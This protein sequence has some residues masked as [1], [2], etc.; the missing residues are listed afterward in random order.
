MHIIKL[1]SRAILAA[2][3][4]ALPAAAFHPN[5]PQG[6]DPERAYQGL[7]QIDQIDLFSGRLTL[8]LPI[9]PF[10]LIYNSNVWRYVFD[11]ES[12]LEAWPD[13][14]STAGL[15]WHL[16]W[17]EVY[18]PDH[19]WYN[20]SEEWLYVSEDGGRHTF[21]QELH[22]GEDDGDLRVFYTRDGSYLRMTL[23]ADNCH[24]DI[25]FPDGTTRRF[26]GKLGHCGPDT[27]RIFSKMWNRFG[28]VHDPD[29]TVSYENDDTL[30]K[31]TDRYGRQHEVYLKKINDV[32]EGSPIAWMNRVVTEIRVQAPHNQTAI[33]KLHYVNSNQYLT[34]VSCKAGLANQ[35]A[36][37]RV[38]LL[39][40]VELPDGTSYDFADHFNPAAT[41]VPF[42]NR[43]CAAGIDD[44]PGTLQGVD[45]PTRGKLR[46]DYQRY[47]FPP[48]DNHSPFNT[49]AGVATRRM[50]FADDSEHGRWTYKTTSIARSDHDDAEMQTEVIYPTGDCTKHF[51]NARYWVTPSQGKGWEY[52]LPFT[53]LAP[54]EG[55][56]HL[57]TET[58]TSSTGTAC[59]GTK[60]RSTYL[61][62]RHDKLPGSV[63][64]DVNPAPGCATEADWLARNRQVDGTRV[65]YHDDVRNGVA[66][67]TDTELNGFDGLGHFRKT[68]STGSF[69][70]ASQ[71]EEQRA[72]VID[73]SRSAGVYTGQ[74]GQTYV[75]I[76]TSTPWVLGIFDSI[77]SSE[78]EATGETAGRTEYRFDTDTGALQCT[79]VLASGMTRGGHDLL[80]LHSHDA[81]G[82]VTD[83]KRYGG[84]T[85][86]LATNDEDCGTAPA[87]PAY[88]SRHTYEKGVRKTTRPIKP[89]GT[90]G[91]FLTYDADLDNGTGVVI[92]RRSPSGLHVDTTYD[93]MGRVVSIEPQEG[94]ETTYAYPAATAS[95]PAK[96]SVLRK[97]GFAVVGQSETIYDDFGRAVRGRARL[98]D[99]PGQP[100]VEI[101]SER[102]T[103]YNARGWTTAV[104]EPGDL[105]KQT[106]FLDF[107]SF[108][109]A[110]RIRPPEG[111][112]HDVVV[113]H[114]GE[115][116]ATTTFEIKTSTTP[117]APLTASHTTHVFDSH[118]RLRRVWER[119]AAD[120]SLVPTSHAYDVAN[121]LTRVS[122]GGAV[123]QQVRAYTYDNRGFMLAEQ[124]PEKGVVG[125]GI[126]H[127]FE[128][129]AAGKAGRVVDGPHDLSFSRDFMGRVLTTRDGNRNHRLVT[130][131]IYDTGSGHGTGLPHRTSRYNYLDLPWTPT[132]TEEAVRV[133]QVYAYQGLGGAVSARQT[134]FVWPDTIDTFELELDYDSEGNL[135]M[136][137]HPRCTSA[138]C[139]GTPAA[140]APSVHYDHQ[141][142]RLTKMPGWVDAFRYRTSGMVAAI[143]HANGVSDLHQADPNRAMRIGRIQTT[144]ADPISSN[145]DSG[146]CTYDGAGN[147][148]A[149]GDDRFAYDNV[150]RLTRA[151]IPNQAN[152]DYTYDRHGNLTSVT[153]NGFEMQTFAVDGT[154][155]RLSGAVAYD[156]A[157]NLTGWGPQQFRYDTSNRLIAQ[158]WMRYLY[159]AAGE[160]AA[161][162]A[163]VPQ[164]NVIYHLRDLGNH[165]ITD[166]AYA[167]GAFER[168]RDWMFA[169][170]RAIGFDEGGKHYHQHLDHLGTPRLIT[171]GGGQRTETR[172]LMPYGQ[173]VNDPGATY[174]DSH[175]FTGHERDA[176]TEADYMH[177]RHY[178]WK[179]G[180]FLSV[181]ELRGSANTPQSLNRYAYVMGNPVALVDPDGR[182]PIG[183][184]W[185]LKTLAEQHSRTFEDTII[186]NSTGLRIP[187]GDALKGWV[188]DV[189]RRA[190]T[191]AGS[192]RLRLLDVV[193]SA[194]NETPGEKLEELLVDAA[195]QFEEEGGDPS[196]L[197]IGCDAIF[198]PGFAAVGVLGAGL[199]GGISL[200]VS[201]FSTVS[202]T[203]TVPFAVGE[204]V[205]VL[206]GIYG[207][208]GDWEEWGVGIEWMV[209][210]P[211]GGPVG[212]VS[213]ALDF[214]GNRGGSGFA[215][216]GFGQALVAGGAGGVTYTWTLDDKCK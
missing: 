97:L 15:G 193:E 163:N 162:I 84:D 108:G 69:W 2:L 164:R 129:D 213:F 66:T 20:D 143:D 80:T 74:P 190:R 73:Y 17:G 90:S 78:S 100:G 142:G 151:E 13:R 154:T 185:K 21:Y 198:H 134:R 56:K 175:L 114:K 6:F 119:S 50:L 125:N 173:N 177:T 205:G 98:P 11:T 188:F 121:R 130:K 42:Y 111:A 148:T 68:V 47:E 103:T 208:G 194:L 93:A 29:L 14:Q 82:L 206:G 71:H 64:A 195:E 170:D 22:K 172:Q 141:R 104:S 122:S 112:A 44:L 178:L 67:Y 95:A 196:L 3:V 155:N 77:E 39:A 40:R 51:F 136:L 169:G 59:S 35:G 199:G 192:G 180:R 70:E 48:G 135:E 102:E 30:R 132:T 87:Q 38:P 79:R 176:S 26:S 211:I 126:V 43:Q 139:N 4:F 168:S 24:T 146:V 81:R 128:F 204:G 138:G 1:F 181:D 197:G 65:T 216:V 37:I 60:L 110:G 109:R 86:A 158:A 120:G 210:S 187:G 201:I 200:D 156:G 33:Y 91:P 105:G 145:F 23:S 137:R 10:T 161:S 191:G 159:D 118:G 184:L 92:R 88:W 113:T 152:Q 183:N 85:Q 83:V 116:L 215:G 27:E 209:G 101:W 25:E 36:S 57:S 32:L 127:Y 167:A 41:P 179:I 28:S 117:A 9:G 76:A 62:F 34:Q 5:Q 52:G 96:T 106:T 55:N 94:P 58:W 16:G 202:L 46:W 49:A 165:H 160:R 189:L 72:T 7:D 214:F 166:V 124:H 107:D 54:Q 12:G 186:V 153:T 212:G 133:D 131:T 75:P 157:G 149:Q 150:G 182:L 207:S 61:R 115:R 53:K 45:L 147:I 123:D 18:H 89:N 99:T 63:C 31:V 140:T 144:G 203:A 19:F 174:T 8:T 171:N